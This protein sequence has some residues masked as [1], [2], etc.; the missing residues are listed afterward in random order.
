[1]SEL[2]KLEAVSERSQAIGEFLEWIFGTKKYHI[3]K[4]LTDG[5][6]ESTDNVYWVDRLYG[7][8]Q[9]K[10]HRIGK[11]ELMSVYINIEKLLA[12]FFE[13]DLN[14]VEK[15]RRKILEEITK[16]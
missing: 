10:R 6:Y 16:K 11:E 2:E 9:Y 5:E 4:Y 15:E 13:I 14:K 1:M 8:D 7:K 12:E 3:A